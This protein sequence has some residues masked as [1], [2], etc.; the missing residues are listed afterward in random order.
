MTEAE[1][2]KRKSFLLM[3]RWQRLL[4]RSSNVRNLSI[5][6]GMLLCPAAAEARIIYVNQAVS[7][8]GNG[9]DWGTAYR[10]LQLAL[11]SS[12]AGDS[13]YLAKGTYYPDALG[14]ID[15]VNYVFVGGDRERSFV[16]NGVKV[17]GGFVGNEASLNDRN[18]SLNVTTLS[19]AI[20]PVDPTNF[21]TEGGERYWSLHVV[22]LA[23]NSTLDGVVIEKGRANGDEQPANQGA[24]IFAPS[25]FTVT[26]NN[27]TVQDNQA[28]ESG[29]GISGNVVATHSKFLGNFI[30]NMF[31]YTKNK[32]VRSWIY[33]PAGRGGAISGDVTATDCDFVG[34]YIDTE[35]TGSENSASATGGAIAGT[36]MNLRECLFEGN[37]AESNASPTVSEPHVSDG[38]SRGGAVSATNL[39]KAIS[40]KFIG[41]G[42]KAAAFADISGGPNFKENPSRGYTAT[43]IVNGGAVAGPLEAVNCV[44]SANEAFGLTYLGDNTINDVLGGAIFTEGNSLVTN[45]VLVGNK[46]SR[47]ANLFASGTDPSRESTIA[48]GGLHVSSGTTVVMNSTFLDNIAS[49]IYS[50]KANPSPR[51]PRSSPDNLSGSA[52][53]TSASLK[54]LSNIVW[55]QTRNFSLIRVINIDGSSARIS[56]RLYA[57]PSTE[58][59]NILKGG[60]AGVASGGN[61][62][63]GDPLTRTLPGAD[64]LFADISNPIGPDGK[65]GTADDG[66][67]ILA[68]SPAID[69]G[70]PLFIPKDPYDLDNDGNVTE[71]IPVDFAGF[72]RIQNGK[73][74]LGAYEF[75]NTSNAPDI[76]VEQ[77][78]ANI[79]VDGTSTVDFGA[80][81]G[82]SKTFIV[83]NTG[84]GDLF[85]LQITGDGLNIDQFNF[86]QP[87]A[88][89]LGGGGSTT[90]TVTF[91]PTI[92]GPVV[93]ALHIAS[94][95]PD[96]S[97]FDI[98]L[99][100]NSL[101]PDIAV[102]YPIGTDLVDAVSVIDYQVVG[103]QSFAVKTVT[104][105]NKGLANLNIASITSSGA[106][107][108]NFVVS[109]LLQSVLASGAST[110]FDLTFTPGGSGLRTADINIVSDDPDAEST[111]LLKVVG[112]GSTSPEIAISQPFAADLVDGGTTSFGSVKKGLLL[113]KKFVIR[114]A[115][116]APLTKLAASIS[117]SGMFTV[118]KL[119]TTELAPGATTEFKV[120]FKPSAL[121][122]K[123]AKVIIASNDLDEGQFDMN[124]TG[125]GVSTSSTKK[126]FHLAVSS[127]T[128]SA[129]SVAMNEKGL[130]SVASG[131][132]G[133]KYLVLTVSKPT[134]SGLETAAAEVSS[135]LVDW[136]SGADHTTTLVDSETLLQVRDNIPLQDGQKRFIRLK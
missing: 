88:N 102:D 25:G 27:C 109:N 119:T 91:N 80:I 99:T 45:C 8:P 101:V 63:F 19:G 28:C 7:V 130:V 71:N 132:D 76:S 103:A 26:L 131:D 43:T 62:D 111:F 108:A 52:I 96:E 84:A 121:G 75:G 49:E 95:D 30:N 32:P 23:A 36:T 42:A 77:P 40:C 123:T 135:N 72:R 128:F 47:D 106:N 46:A 124:L 20:W 104:I 44:F 122:K 6:A 9:L 115:G 15:L 13:I 5:L 86:T 97:P 18:P 125:T 34:N 83:K 117:G 85:D 90:F 51:L 65:W 120:T 11:Q 67:R 105:R 100:G 41:N 3:N 64:P 58:T 60:A 134:G 107:A 82:T 1:N 17:Y 68:A 35:S 118:T 54:L 74:D 94:N 93:A 110:T 37:I 92:S 136:Y 79:L 70:N 29:G 59:I 126:S 22:T 48:G 78:L 31:L 116:N 12:V 61:R 16:L 133:L 127:E 39:I 113:S 89:E 10:D 73:L 114:N 50:S 57:T 98:R 4:S 129:R 24:G 66:L 56:N 112:S 69:K 38:T 53:T 2:P 55:D 87:S 14:I 81:R 33:S 21:L